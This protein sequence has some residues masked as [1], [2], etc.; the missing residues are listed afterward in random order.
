MNISELTTKL[1]DQGWKNLHVLPLYPPGR[2]CGPPSLVHNIG[3]LLLSQHC[4]AKNIILLLEH[5]T[6]MSEEDLILIQITAKTV[7]DMLS[8]KDYVTAIGLAGNG[9]VYCK[10][11]LVKATDINKYQLGRYIDN[12]T[13][14]GKRIKI[15]N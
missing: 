6:F 14:K 8:E 1:K 5:G 12:L 11:G 9:F 10:N 15:G 4:S 13:R 7:I 3:P 2:I